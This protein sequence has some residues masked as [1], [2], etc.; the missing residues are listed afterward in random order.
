MGGPRYEVL[1]KSGVFGHIWGFGSKSGLFG[2]KVP[3][4]GLFGSKLV[5]FG[6]LGRGGG[7]K[8]GLIGPALHQLKVRIPPPFCHDSPLKS[9]YKTQ[10]FA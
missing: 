10:V 1:A 9:V 4:S 8:S 7:P 5:I 2:L 6:L 3:E